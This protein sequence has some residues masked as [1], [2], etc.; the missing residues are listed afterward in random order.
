MNLVGKRN[1]YAL[2]KR[3]AKGEAKTNSGN[4]GPTTKEIPGARG[5]GVIVF[6]LGK[7]GGTTGPRAIPQGADP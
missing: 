4:C 6:V 2:V 5:A 3:T 1:G 7:V